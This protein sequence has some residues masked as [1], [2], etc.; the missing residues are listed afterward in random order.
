MNFKEQCRVFAVNMVSWRFER[1][2]LASVVVWNARLFNSVIMISNSKEKNEK[3]LKGIIQVSL[4][5][6]SIKI[7]NTLSSR[8]SRHWVQSVCW[9]WICYKQEQVYVIWSCG[10]LDHFYFDKRLELEN[11][12]KLAFVFKFIFSLGNAFS[13][14]W[15]EDSVSQILSKE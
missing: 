8:W 3:L 9:E 5:L 11:Y 15:S 1:C 7:S 12:A 4:A 2:P 6:D 10:R 14:P 13:H